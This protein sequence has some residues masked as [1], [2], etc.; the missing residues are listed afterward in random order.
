[1]ACGKA[2]D[3]DWTSDMY[4][5]HTASIEPSFDP[6]TI[7]DECTVSIP[8]NIVDGTAI[9]GA[10]SYDNATGSI[11]VTEKRVPSFN[12]KFSPGG[13]AEAA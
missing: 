3:F 4:I 13:H 9:V 5:V 10:D 12:A 7:T 6:S 8:S 1:M 11:A 2:C